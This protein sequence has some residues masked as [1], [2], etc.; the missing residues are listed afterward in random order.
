[1][2]KKNMAVFMILAS[3]LLSPSAFGQSLTLIEDENL[4]YSSAYIQNVVPLDSAGYFA[5]LGTAGTQYLRI[6]TF[7]IDPQTGDVDA[8]IDSVVVEYQGSTYFPNLNRIQESNYYAALFDGSTNEKTKLET[9]EISPRGNISAVIDSIIVRSDGIGGG[10]MGYCGGNDMYA[11]SYT[12]GGT[13]NLFLET[14]QISDADGGISDAL[15]DSIKVTTAYTYRTYTEH[16]T[17]GESGWSMV[18]YYDGNQYPWLLPFH[19]DTTD[20]SITKGT[21][22]RAENNAGRGNNMKALALNDSIFLYS[23]RQYG[24]ATGTVQSYKISQ[25]G[26]ITYIDKGTVLHVSE[27]E[28]S[29]LGLAAMAR[30]DSDSLI[31]LSGIGYTGGGMA[32]LFT[33]NPANGN[34][35]YPCPALDSLI[36]FINDAACADIRACI[37]DPDSSCWGGLYFNISNAGVGELA[38]GLHIQSYGISS[39]WPHKIYGIEPGKVYGIGK[40]SFKKIS[41][42]E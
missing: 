20:G 31:I 26:V 40:D 3:F 5:V 14:F 2:I 15:H 11:V 23:Y 10:A 34:I 6:R 32:A 16:V 9:Y 39:G 35:E 1:M 30:V 25:S 41:G 27:G 28:N 8:F 22:V 13:P 18:T 17:C 12:A 4:T 33:C 37:I 29:G 36:L 7:Y 19:V 21:V 42:I 38:Q 24:G